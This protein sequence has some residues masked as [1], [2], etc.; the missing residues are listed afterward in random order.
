MEELEQQRQE[1]Q[2][3]AATTAAGG[4]GGVAVGKLH[5]PSLWEP[6]NGLTKMIASLRRKYQLQEE[7]GL[8]QQQTNSSVGVGVGVGTQRSHSMHLDSDNPPNQFSHQEW[9]SLK[10]ALCNDDGAAKLKDIAEAMHIAQR[11]YGELRN[12]VGTKGRVLAEIAAKLYVVGGG[13]GG[14][15]GGY[16]PLNDQL[17]AMRGQLA[18]QTFVP[19]RVFDATT[20]RHLLTL[21]TLGNKASHPGGISPRD[22]PDIVHAMYAVASGFRPAA[23][24]SPT[25][26]VAQILD[27]MCRARDA[28]L[29][30]SSVLP[31]AAVAGPPGSPSKRTATSGPPSK[32]GGVGAGGAHTLSNGKGKPSAPLP[33]KG[34]VSDPRS[35]TGVLSAMVRYV[36]VLACGYV[37]AEYCHARYISSTSGEDADDGWRLEL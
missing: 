7:Q 30:A 23:A 10:D 36:V 12:T 8:Q 3:T 13:G 15:S 17:A 25:A 31:V 21:Q 29:W 18:S 9:M 35:A 26:E 4:G 28:Y 24:V 14:A 37:I 1:R 22:R 6:E 20:M 34:F 33:F 19:G 27:R 16:V 2:I 32:Q 11:Y 5:Q